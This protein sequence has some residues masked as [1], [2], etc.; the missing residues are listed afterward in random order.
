MTGY[1][2]NVFSSE[3]KNEY[4][5]AM[6]FHVIEKAGTSLM[7]LVNHGITEE[8]SFNTFQTLSTF[9]FY[10]SWNGG[11][12]NFVFSSQIR[13]FSEMDLLERLFEQVS[14]ELFAVFQIEFDL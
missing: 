7:A 9:T 14:I 2:V 4:P 3:K 11:H 6:T 5:I 8:W 13:S 10:S 1:T 12:W